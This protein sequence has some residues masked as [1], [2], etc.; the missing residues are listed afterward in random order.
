VFFEIVADEYWRGYLS[1]NDSIIVELFTGQFKSK[2][3][4]P[5]CH[6][7]RVLLAREQ[8]LLVFYPLQ[9]SVTFDPFTSI[10][11]P[12]PKRTAVDT[13]VTYRNDEQ[14]STK[15]RVVMSSDGS[16]AEFKQLLAAKCG[17]PTNKVSVT[18]EH[19]DRC[20]GSLSS[21]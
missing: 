8:T 4:C 16:I 12:L 2:T 3:K 14:P 5:Q 15:F 18:L 10:S 20:T 11:V 1:R 6:R 17:L 21:R 9:E 19:R 7:V 13:I